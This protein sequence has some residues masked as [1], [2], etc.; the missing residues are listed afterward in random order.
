M[1]DIMVLA[2][3]S[4]STRVATFMFGNAVSGR[5]FSFLEGVSGGHHSI[6]H[7]KGDGNQLDQYQVINTWHV[8]Q[9]AYMLQRMKEIKEDNGTLLD[10]SMVLFGSGIRDGN[11]HNPHDVPIVLAGKANGQL[12][13]GR[14]LSY[15]RDTPLC[16]LYQGML[17][18]VGAKV[19]K[20]GDS[21]GELP[22]L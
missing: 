4:D 5:N 17:K 1:M 15:D 9:Y 6:S 21:S 19:E 3:W 10:H 12:K 8:T 11:Q 2:L 22:N 13:T 16:N 14:R 18:R 7:H 20:F